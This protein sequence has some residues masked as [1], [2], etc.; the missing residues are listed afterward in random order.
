VQTK[1]I[2]KQN[3]KYKNKLDKG[4]VCAFWVETVEMFLVELYVKHILLWWI[5]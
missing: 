1:Q 5:S 2:K 4:T 3:A